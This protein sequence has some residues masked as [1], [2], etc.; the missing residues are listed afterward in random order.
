MGYTEGYTLPVSGP[1]QLGLACKGW[2]VLKYVQRIQD[3][4]AVKLIGLPMVETSI[5]HLNPKP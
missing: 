2:Y 5:L 4:E 3:L 1:E